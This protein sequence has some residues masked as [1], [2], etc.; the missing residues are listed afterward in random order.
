M[1]V[2][3]DNWRIRRTVVFATLFFCAFNITWIM[4]DGTDTALNQQLGLG[5]IAA[6]TAT[7]GSYVF[8][9]CWDDMNKRK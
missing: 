5:L 7:I 3:E 9:A 4:L 6:A 8:G 2:P 1:N